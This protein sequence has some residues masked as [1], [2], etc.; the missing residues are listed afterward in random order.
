MHT[1]I[2]KSGPTKSNLL[3]SFIFEMKFF[4][5]SLFL[6]KILTKDSVTVFVN[7]IMYYKV[8]KMK[9]V[10]KGVHVFF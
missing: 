9:Y 2:H 8:G 1:D 4:N 3:N 6:I 10:S 7:A 5:L